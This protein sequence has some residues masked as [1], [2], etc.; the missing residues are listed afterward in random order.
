MIALE[1]RHVIISSDRYSTLRLYSPIDYEVVRIF[2]RLI[3]T[4]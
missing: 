4:A 1:T 2:R 3:F